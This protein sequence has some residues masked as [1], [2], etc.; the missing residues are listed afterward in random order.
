M[1][2][3]ACFPAILLSA[4]FLTVV[5]PEARLTRRILF[6]VDTSGSMRGDKFGQACS[7][8][9]K[10]A[11]QPVDEVEIAVLAFNHGTRRWTGVPEK[12]IPPG[13][14]ALPSLHAT[15]AAAGFL[16]QGGAGG[17]TQVIS[18]LREA[19]AEKRDELSIVLVTDGLFVREKTE[20]VI[21]ALK[22][23]QE[24]RVKNKLKPAVLLVYGI[25]GEMEVLRE[26]GKIGHGG[27]LR[28]V[29]AADLALPAAIPAIQGTVR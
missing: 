16:A 26:L 2:R 10:V 27:Y 17:D 23:G 9:L 25:G 13:W 5:P 15:Q 14:A 18:A 21:Q 7:A 8:V 24:E 12:G 19:L 28:E 3:L 11:E 1:L 22:T 6:V 29:D 20:D 4:G